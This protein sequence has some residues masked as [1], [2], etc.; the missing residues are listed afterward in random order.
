M[1]E[2][3]LGIVPKGTHEWN[4]YVNEDELRRWFA[5]QEGWGEVKSLGVMYVPGFGWK[6]IKGGEDW[7]NYFLGV[8][9]EE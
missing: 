7:G 9:R 2:D 4:K 3:V 5:G 1:A 8:R 6:E